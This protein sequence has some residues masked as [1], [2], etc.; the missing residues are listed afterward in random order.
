MI[1]KIKEA[2]KRNAFA[3]TLKACL[4]IFRIKTAEGFQYRTAGL[5]GA[6]TNIFWVLIEITV[7]TVFYKYADNKQA[8]MIAGLSLEQI[9]S[10]AWLTQL[11]FLMQPM[12]ID[13]EILGKITSGDVGIEM[14]RPI[15]LYFHWFAKTAATRL[16]PLFIRGSITLLFGIIIPGSYGLSLPASFSGFVCALASAASAFILC[17]SYAMLMYSIRI[18]I[19][20]GEGPTYI[21]MLIGGVLSGGYLPLQLWPRFMQGF[22]LV[23][24]FAGYMDIPLR[25]YIGS[26]APKDA[27]WA[28]GLQI[29][30]TAAFIA[31][32]KLIMNSRLKHIIVQ[33]G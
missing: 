8:G 4:S 15:D 13:A 32:G 3:P 24:P 10:Y 16:T 11:L 21:L 18:N 19:T 14:C 25:F 5:A 7:Y 22:L 12:N 17:T 1:K 27:I 23:Q 6:S 31:A 26:M 33:G 30:W 9:I 28:I 2:K 20:W 29:V